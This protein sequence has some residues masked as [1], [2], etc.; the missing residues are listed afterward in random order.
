MLPD[1]SDVL[2]FI[3]AVALLIAVSYFFGMAVEIVIGRTLTFVEK[4]IVG[5]AIVLAAALLSR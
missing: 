5:L 1:R 4:M 2:S 3:F